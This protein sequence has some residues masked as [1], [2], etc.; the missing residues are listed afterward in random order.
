MMAS[1]DGFNATKGTKTEANDGSSINIDGGSIAVNCTKGD[2]LDS[3]GD[4]TINS[5]TVIVHGPQSQPEVGFDVN[6]TFRINGGF[7][8]ATGPNSGN[9]IE[10]PATSSTQFSVR[11]TFQSGL[12]PSSLFHIED[13]GGKNIITFKP[14]R[15]IYYIV[16]STPAF[17]SGSSYS[18]YTG[19]TTTGINANG[20]YNDGVYS[21]GTLRKTFTVSGK[22]TGISI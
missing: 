6:G 17:I 20:I 15:S 19:G 4:I 2:G 11:I 12:L 7:F 5:G 13:S 16:V 1:N 22:V 3:N 8:V 10:V 21:G 9:M 18:I 14:A